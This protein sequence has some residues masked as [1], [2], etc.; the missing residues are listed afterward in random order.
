MGELAH[1]LAL[2]CAGG[3]AFADTALLAA[4]LRDITSQ[5]LTHLA[6]AHSGHETIADLVLPDDV[7]DRLTELATR[8]RQRYRVMHDWGFGGDATRRVGVTALF[9]GRPGRGRRPPSVP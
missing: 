2:R 9:S 3:A 6:T 7:K 5:R 8:L 1:E 4:T